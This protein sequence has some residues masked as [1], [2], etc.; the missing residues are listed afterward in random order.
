MRA[1]LLWLTNFIASFLQKGKKLELLK[2]TDPR[3]YP[4][5]NQ[6]GCFFMSIITAS[7]KYTGTVFNADK[8]NAL[9][10]SARKLGILAN[11]NGFWILQKPHELGHL[12]GDGKIETFA[13]V[14]VI[15]GWE[16]TWYAGHTYII[17]KGQTSTGEHYRLGDHEGVLIYDP[18][19]SVKI[20][21][22]LT[23]EYY[24]VK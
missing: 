24:L 1:L 20:T 8:I 4:E 2:Q 5:I 7:Q 3:L 10:D 22:E 11:V 9:W 6:Y 19:P 23:K 21:Q 15:P 14:K 17:L 18:M 12:A 13:N 16:P